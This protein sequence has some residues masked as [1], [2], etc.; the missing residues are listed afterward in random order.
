MKRFFK[1]ILLAFAGLI[2]FLGMS[3]K[4]KNN[5]EQDAIRLP[6]INEIA[7]VED[8]ELAAYHN[9]A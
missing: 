5:T 6:E 2:S 3:K 7:V 1:F 8:Y 4:D 9:Q